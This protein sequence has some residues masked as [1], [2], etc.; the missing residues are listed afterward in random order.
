M[1][2]RWKVCKI[3]ETDSLSYRQIH[4]QTGASLTTITRVARFLKLEPHQGYANV[5]EKIKRNSNK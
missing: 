2:E 3:L 5:L 1:A 4:Q